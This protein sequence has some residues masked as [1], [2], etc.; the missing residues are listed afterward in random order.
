M[1][2]I[3]KTVIDFI[4]VFI[5]KSK[6]PTNKLASLFKY[7]FIIGLP[8][9]IVGSLIFSIVA[10]DNEL[11]KVETIAKS[12]K[13]KELTQ[14]NKTSVSDIQK[15]IESSKSAVKIT[16]EI[17]VINKVVAKETTIIKDRKDKKLVAIRKTSEVP[18]I[19]QVEKEKYDTEEST[20]NI[21]AMW[22]SYCSVSNQCKEG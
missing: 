18:N 22:E 19:T 17:D 15:Y 12:E 8:V 13:I 5:F 16:Q 7:G 4:T 14:V 21:V 9:I 2:S 6:E 20:V 3:L 11:L 1:H 10:K